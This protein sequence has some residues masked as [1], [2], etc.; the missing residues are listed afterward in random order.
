MDKDFKL[1]WRDRVWRWFQS[2][3]R[4]RKCDGCK[5][6]FTLNRIDPASGDAWLCEPC[7]RRWYPEFAEDRHV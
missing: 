1:S 6:N 7:F 4:R 3:L 2:R 5:G